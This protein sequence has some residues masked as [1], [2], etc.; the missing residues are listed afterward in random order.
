FFA[1]MQMK[2]FLSFCLMVFVVS[3]IADGFR[4]AM[5]ASISAYAKKEN[6]NRSLSLIRLAI[7]LGF[8]AGAAVTGFIALHFGYRWLFIIDGLTCILAAFFLLWALEPKE[9]VLSKEEAKIISEDGIGSSAYADHRYLL[10]V[11]FQ[12]LSAIVFMQLFSTVPVFMKD[13]LLFSEA[14]YGVVMMVNGLIIVLVEMPL[15]YI[16]EKHFERM[17]LVVLGY[18]LI[19]SGFA[20]LM[21]AEA[22]VHMIMS[23]FIIAISIGEVVCFPFSNSFALSRSTPGRR[24]Q[25][26]GLYSMGFSTAFIIAPSLGLHIAEVYGFEMLWLGMGI[27][28]M[29]ALLG[30][31]WIRQTEKKPAEKTTGFG[32]V[33]KE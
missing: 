17:T 7:N 5:M 1:L 21:V 33:N 27:L 29:I 10:F 19:V 4:P 18:A 9:E 22:S 32:L 12:M 31:V 30:F 23:Y 6:Y 20:S 3:S 14:E 24:G 15:V 13:N 26:M 28:G 8:A 25:Y 2:T 16:L 11:F